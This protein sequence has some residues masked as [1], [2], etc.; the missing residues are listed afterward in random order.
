[1]QMFALVLVLSIGKSLYCPLL[2]KG[3][4]PRNCVVS[5]FGGLFIPV[6]NMVLFALTLS[7]YCLVSVA[8]GEVKDPAGCEKSNSYLIWL[9]CN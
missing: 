4:I 7:L 8:T 5:G 2:D 3:I 1:M 6:Y 9:S